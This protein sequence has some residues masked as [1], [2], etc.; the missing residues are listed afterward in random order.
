MLWLPDCVI[1]VAYDR[2]ISDL[3]RY[4]YE[5]AHSDLVLHCGEDRIY[6]QKNILCTWSEHFKEFFQDLPQITDGG[7]ILEGDD[8]TTIRALMCRATSG[9]VDGKAIAL[10]QMGNGI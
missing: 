3:R 8:P 1:R 5:K 4:F 2:P 6:G 9:V 10:Q 7:L